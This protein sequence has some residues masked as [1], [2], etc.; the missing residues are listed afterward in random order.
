MIT[1]LFKPTEQCEYHKIIETKING[2]KQQ[3]SIIY[4]MSADKLY[5]ILSHE[6]NFQNAAQ[7]KTEVQTWLSTED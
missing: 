2:S 7:V 1:Y 3:N 6:R 4:S 5:K